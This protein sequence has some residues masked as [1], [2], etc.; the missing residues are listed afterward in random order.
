MSSH[1]DDLD[2]RIKKLENDLKKSRKRE[3]GDGDEPMV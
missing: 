3:G 1:E 2:E